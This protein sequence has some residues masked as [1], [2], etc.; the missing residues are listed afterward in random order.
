[1]KK[2]KQIWVCIHFIDGV[3]FS[4]YR[5][6]RNLKRNVVEMVNK[7]ISSWLSWKLSSIHKKRLMKD[8]HFE[9]QDEHGYI[10]ALVLLKVPARV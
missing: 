3:V 4:H 2:V 5:D 6:P 1:M 9:M 10:H 8:G 7:G